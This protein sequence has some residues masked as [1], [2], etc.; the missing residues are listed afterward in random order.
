MYVRSSN[1]NAAKGL[2][3]NNN[4][5]TNSFVYSLGLIAGASVVL[6]DPEFNHNGAILKNISFFVRVAALNPSYVGFCI[7]NVPPQSFMDGLFILSPSQ[8]SYSATDCI[9]SGQ[10]NGDI[11]I[12][13]NK[14][15]F[16]YANTGITTSLITCSFFKK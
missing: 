10:L 9:S 6:I 16:F 14:G 13:P 3:N 1:E 8:F 2:L 5:I 11:Y 12:E 15:L 7:N 4:I